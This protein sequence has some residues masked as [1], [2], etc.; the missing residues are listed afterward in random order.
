MG[1]VEAVVKFPVFHE[2]EDVV[3]LGFSPTGQ[4]VMT[5]SAKTTLAVWSIRGELLAQ[6]D[7]Y[8]MSTYC[9]EVSPCGR[10]V[11]TSGFTPDVKVIK[12]HNLACLSLVYLLLA[13]SQVWEVKFNRSGEF[14]KLARAFELTGH[15]S[16]VF[17]FAF[18]ADSS[19]VA[20]LGKDNTWRVFRIDV[21]FTRGQVMVDNLATCSID[22]D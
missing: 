12:S 11:A 3:G 4:Y 8:H 18:S 19:R 13:L 21:D 22:L 14:E 6:A 16:G 20:T 1:A 10:F 5:C 15:S 9:A 2:T 7:T 17:A